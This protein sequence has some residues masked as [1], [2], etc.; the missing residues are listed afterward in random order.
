ME[1]LPVPESEIKAPATVKVKKDIK[2]Y[3]LNPEWKAKHLAYC[4]ERVICPDCG[5]SYTRNCKTTHMKSK[6][7]LAPIMSKQ[8]ELEE[9][10]KKLEAQLAAKQ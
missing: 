4:Y 10:I 8:A 7:H 6:K 2:F 5:N 9:I 1:N 3:Y